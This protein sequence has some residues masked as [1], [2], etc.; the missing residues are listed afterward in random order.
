MTTCSS[1]SVTEGMHGNA[2]QSCL[3]K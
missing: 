3:C 2:A 1:R